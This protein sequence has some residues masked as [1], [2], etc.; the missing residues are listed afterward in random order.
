MNLETGNILHLVVLN[1]ATIVEVSVSQSLEDYD[2]PFRVFTNV[3]EICLGSLNDVHVYLQT[4]AESDWWE[5]RINDYLD[6]QNEIIDH[7]K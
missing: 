2:A 5:K 1:G 7:L 3:P 6:L 4:P